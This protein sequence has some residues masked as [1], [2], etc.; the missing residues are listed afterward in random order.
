MVG[1]FL[2]NCW[3]AV[4]A[5]TIYF[6]ITFQSLNTPTSIIVKSFVVAIIVF[7]ATYLVRFIIAFVMYTPE[8][9]QDDANVQSE[10]QS[11]G[12]SKNEDEDEDIENLR[13]EKTSEKITVDQAEELAKSV[14][15]M[16]ANDE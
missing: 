11:Q 16:M 15:T 14:K 8:E 12:Q 2:S 13:K 1:T 5:F 9:N 6:L 7:F 10:R 3:A 4:I